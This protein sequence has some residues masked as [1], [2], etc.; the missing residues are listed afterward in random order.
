MPNTLVRG[1]SPVHF[2]VRSAAG[3][4]SAG[5]DTLLATTRIRPAACCY[6]LSPHHGDDARLIALGS[7][8][9]DDDTRARIWGRLIERACLRAAGEGKLRVS[10]RSEEGS[11]CSRLLRRLGFTTVTGEQVFAR[12]CGPPPR[13]P[14]PNLVPLRSDDAWDVWKLYNRTEPATVQRAEGLTPSSWWKG[15][16]LRRRPYQEWILRVDGNVVVHEELIYGRRYAALSLH[17]DPTYRGCLD[18]AIEHAISVCADR[19]LTA[20]YCTIREHQ[21]ELEGLLE[22]AG[23]ELARAQTHLVLYTSVL[24]YVQEGHSLP[25][26]DRGSPVFRTTM[27]RLSDHRDNPSSRKADRYN[28]VKGN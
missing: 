27:S 13:R 20:M 18:S 2:A 24:G 6:S 16:R 25:V 19:G 22:H 23:F 9:E 10:A 28:I 11:D 4:L 12:A 5:A 14:S 21:T 17:Y 15:R 1:F 7:F 8:R 3:P 26:V